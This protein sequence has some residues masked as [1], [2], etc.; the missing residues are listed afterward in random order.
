MLKITNKIDLDSLCDFFNLIRNEPYFQPHSFNISD[1]RDYRD[2]AGEYW[3]ITLKGAII[4]YGFIR[5]WGDAWPEK[6]VGLCVGPLHRGEGF[7]EL[8]LRWLEK[9]ASCRGLDSLRIHVCEDNLPAYSL[10]KKMGYIFDETK[11]E[12]GDLIG[13]K[14]L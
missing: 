11:T 13:R 12:K 10:Y 1:W 8:M 9:V 3:V 7:G 4:A 14:V 2:F 6:V 5:G